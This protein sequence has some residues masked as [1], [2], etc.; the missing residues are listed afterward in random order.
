MTP[1][2]FSRRNAQKGLYAN[3]L[4]HMERHVEL[5]TYM[6]GLRCEMV[7]NVAMFSI[8]LG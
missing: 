7:M 6:V 2:P 4:E 8:R 3:L 5:C 1:R